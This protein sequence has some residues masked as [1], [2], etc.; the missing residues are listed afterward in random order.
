MRAAKGAAGT[1]SPESA[2][3]QKEVRRSE[4]VGDSEANRFRAAAVADFTS[5]H[6]LPVRPGAL[7]SC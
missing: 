5:D 4:P 3:T 6:G 7:R 1:A 2:I